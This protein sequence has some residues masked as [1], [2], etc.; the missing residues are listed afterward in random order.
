MPSSGIF[1]KRWWEVPQKAPCRTSFLC[2]HQ[3][4]SSRADASSAASARW[5]GTGDAR[6][7][8][9]TGRIPKTEDAMDAQ[10]PQGTLGVSLNLILLKGTYF[11]NLF[12]R[13]CRKIFFFFFLN[14]H[15]TPIFLF[16]LPYCCSLC[17]SQ[18]VAL[19]IEACSLSSTCLPGQG[20]AIS[21]KFITPTPYQW[22]AGAR[23]AFIITEGP[24]IWKTAASL[25]VW[26]ITFRS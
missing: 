21:E 2:P 8:S 12:D 6:S 16:P 22:K 20:K 10:C 19:Q 9:T 26:L 4:R 15:S 1:D 7:E 25:K 23:E 14:H 13:L 11:S 24:A 18:Q 3:P 5:A 17:T